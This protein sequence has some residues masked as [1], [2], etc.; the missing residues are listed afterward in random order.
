MPIS[1]APYSTRRDDQSAIF[2]E[3]HAN[4]PVLPPA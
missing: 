4:S 1:A 2:P 3:Q